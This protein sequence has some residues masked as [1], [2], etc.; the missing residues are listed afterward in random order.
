MNISIIV[1]NVCDLGGIERSSF[2]LAKN[3]RKAGH[4]V[5]LV[6][7]YENN[8]VALNSTERYR[9]LKGSNE[10][11]KLK[12]YINTLDESTIIIS[13]YD[14]LSFIISLIFFFSNKKNKLIAHQHAD[15]FAHSLK[16]RFLRK[17]AYK[18]GCDAIVCLT[19]VDFKLYKKWHKKCYVI[20]N[21]LDTDFI[22]NEIHN[23]FSTRETD[24]L[25]GGR[26]HP[27]K[28]FEDFIKLHDDLTKKNSLSF[29]LF[30]HGS[31]YHR[32]CNISSSANKVIQGSTKK[33]FVEMQNSKFFI[34]TS[35]RESFSM[36]IVEAMAAGC[37]VISYSCPTGPGEIITD[38]YD[39]YLIPDGDYSSL[40]KK[41][42]E[43][44]QNEQELIQVSENA[45]ITAQKY[46][47]E[48]VIKKWDSLFL[49][50]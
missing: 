18:I 24:F 16:V 29:K 50:L 6:S 20:P 36:V 22:T 26:L 12:K 39:G 3:L 17:I 31:D 8:E 1:L 42:S 4:N 5:E 7:L 28:R 13:A 2:T 44:L 21:I 33:M 48:N 45:K 34:V 41:C 9:V 19:N 23:D 15:Y 35:H 14:R 47:P 11:V 37:I 32:L 27:I 25:A 38:G 40:Y 30:G 43:L 46:W 10:F 49:N